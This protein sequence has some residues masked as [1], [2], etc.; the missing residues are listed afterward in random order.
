M[1]HLILS[2]FKGVS[3]HY[4]SKFKDLI[5]KNV[6]NAPAVLPQQIISPSQKPIDSQNIPVRVNTPLQVQNIASGVIDEK[7]LRR[8]SIKHVKDF[9][10]KMQAT[11]V[12]GEPFTPILCIMSNLLKVAGYIEQKAPSIIQL[13]KDTEETEGHDI[14]E[15]TRDLK[16]AIG[17]Y[18]TI[19]G[20]MLQSILKNRPY[21]FDRQLVY[22]D[23]HRVI[24]YINDPKTLPDPDLQEW[25]DNTQP[26]VQQMVKV[27]RVSVPMDTNMGQFLHFMINT[28][29]SSKKIIINGGPSEDQVS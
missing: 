10:E 12:F 7:E 18:D 17:R 29:L 21:P 4:D 9:R 27:L 5:Q 16:V 2:A 22:Q 11:G 3:S 20:R 8:I 23:I 15:V 6:K 28:S 1:L 19:V 14:L 13:S 26:V 24:N 25:F